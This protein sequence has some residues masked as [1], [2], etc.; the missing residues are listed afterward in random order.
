MEFLYLIP[1]IKLTFTPILMLLVLVSTSPSKIQEHA[2]GFN[3][4]N[5]D[6]GCLT[7]LKNKCL[8]APKAANYPSV[9]SCL[10]AL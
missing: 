3:F 8:S 9:S 7:E 5:V 2:E 4:T 1:P 6:E 10:T